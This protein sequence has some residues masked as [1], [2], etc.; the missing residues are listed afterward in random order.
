MPTEIM[1]MLLNW[2]VLGLVAFLF[3]KQNAEDRER[4]YQSD[5]AKE[6]TLLNNAKVFEGLE[7]S[8]KQLNMT[9]ENHNLRWDEISKTLEDI[10]G[11]LRGHDK[12][13][14]KVLTEI[15]ANNKVF[16]TK[17]DAIIRESFDRRTSMDIFSKALL[18]E[19]EADLMR[20]ESKEMEEEE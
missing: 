6:Q 2:G 13:G 1:Q 5:K 9:L 16:S 4:Y 7:S 14:E 10:K 11:I 12:Q 3:F 15:L 18:S 8:I 20:K 17:I 19:K